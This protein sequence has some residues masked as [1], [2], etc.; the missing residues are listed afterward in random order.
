MVGLLR[1]WQPVLQPPP[2]LASLRREVDC[3]A[4]GICGA[5]AV[6]VAW[7]G[8]LADVLVVMTLWRVFA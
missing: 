6:Y 2:I 8:V 4:A 5:G 7:R 3:I 1:H